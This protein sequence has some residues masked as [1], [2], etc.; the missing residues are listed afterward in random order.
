MGRLIELRQ[1]LLTGSYPVG[2]EAESSGALKIAYMR[3]DPKIN[4]EKLSGNNL[5]KGYRK[6]ERAFDHFMRRVEL[7]NVIEARKELFP[8]A[9]QE[10]QFIL[11]HQVNTTIGIGDTLEVG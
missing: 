10:E 5:L 11:D 2:Q 6:A 9:P 4:S 7:K 3:I 1:M 8:L